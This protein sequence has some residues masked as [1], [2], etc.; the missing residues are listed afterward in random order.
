[1]AAVLLWPT[2]LNWHPYLFWDTYGYFL[3]GKAY[4]K[5]LLAAAGL[6]PM[7]LEAAEGWIGA[8]GRMLASDPSIRS[9]TYSLLLYALAA[10]GGFWL[11]VAA[12][13]LAAAVTVEIAMCRLLRLP[14]PGRLALFLLLAVGTA[15]PWFAGYLMPDLAAGLLILAAATIAFAWPRLR[16]WE[17]SWIVTAYLLAASFHSSHLLLGGGLAALAWPL[18]GRGAGLRLLA[19]VAAAF[20]VL[21][22]AGWLGFGAATPTPQTPPFLLARSWEDGPARTYLEDACG[23]GERWAICGS[24]ATL[25]PSAQGLLWNPEHSYWAMDLPTRAMV[26]A[27]EGPLLRRALA[28]HPL[29]QLEASARNAWR[30]LAR[31]GLDDLV[32]G[33]GATVTPEDY[34]FVYLPAAPAAVWGLAP[35]SVLS[36]AATAI[37]LIV[38]ATRSL[39]RPA[40]PIALFVL[41]GVALNAVVCGV[42]SGPHDRYQARVIWLVPLLAAGL[43]LGR[44]PELSAAPR[45]PA[46]AAP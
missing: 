8:A 1:M 10:A 41:A 39:R 26:R 20:A 21:T 36:Y 34:T 4:A 37:A 13:A 11:V 5:L 25:A 29:A 35:F 27:E 43:A 38:L 32:L 22:G 30:Q 33:R 18:A 6:G 44:A 42:L 23:R 15:L 12:Q 40:P 16:R 3:Q 45:V 2:A 9:P 14:A 24:L 17:R 19:P 31:F 28:A 7:P 46:P